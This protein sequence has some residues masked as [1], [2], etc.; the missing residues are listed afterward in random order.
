MSESII[1]SLTVGTVLG[2]LTGLG[3]GGGSLLVLW[4]T[5]CL[6]YPQSAARGINLL[7]FLPAAIISCLLRW[8][9]GTLDMKACLPGMIAG[10][11]AAALQIQEPMLVESILITV[12]V[13]VS[14]LCH[15]VSSAHGENGR[16][17]E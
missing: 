8:K 14:S 10:C 11:A 17:H 3:V 4:L 12:W 5:L 7:F 1:L 13:G 16:S 15:G 6:N 9:Q 2:V